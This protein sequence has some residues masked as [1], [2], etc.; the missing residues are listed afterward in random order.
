MSILW[1]IATS[2]ECLAGQIAQVILTQTHAAR[3]SELNIQCLGE[4]TPGHFIRHQ[5]RLPTP[6]GKRVVPKNS[7]PCVRLLVSVHDYHHGQ[8]WRT[9]LVSLSSDSRGLLDTTIKGILFSISS[10]LMTKLAISHRKFGPEKKGKFFVHDGLGALLLCPLDLLK[11][12][13]PE[14]DG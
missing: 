1:I 8:R 12:H 14:A 10:Y 13:I 2:P 5:E 4:L 3:G 11:T 7:G 9:N 6:L